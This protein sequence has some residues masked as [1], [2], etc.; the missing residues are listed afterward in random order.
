MKVFINFR[1]KLFTD[2]SK[3]QGKYKK[4]RIDAYQPTNIVNA[5]VEIKTDNNRFD[6]DEVAQ[7]YHISMGLIRRLRVTQRA[8]ETAI[9]GVSLRDLIRNVEIHRRARATDIA[10]R[11]AQLKWQW[12]G[13]IVRRRD[14]R[15]GP[16]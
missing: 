7:P 8:M 4:D 10:Q 2:N 12:A 9:L 6:A 1:T 14:R 13:H 5:K 15:W 16:K 11:V 3:S